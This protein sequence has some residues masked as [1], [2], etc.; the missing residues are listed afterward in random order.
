LYST[1]IDIDYLLT[2][3]A[4]LPDF[5]INRKKLYDL[6]EIVFMSICGVICGCDDYASIKSWSDDN[7]V[8]LRQYLAL[9]NGIPSDDTFRRIFQYLDYEAFNRC[10]MD[11][12]HGLSHLTNGEVISFD[13][14]CLRGSKDK[15]LG[16]WEFTRWGLGQAKINYF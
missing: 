10:F 6:T 5:R 1:T 15:R 12:T 3:F 2:S 16:K 4:S 11:F 8:W 13:G 9:A 7:V 14:K